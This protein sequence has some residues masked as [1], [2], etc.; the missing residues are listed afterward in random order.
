VK[1]PVFI[2]SLHYRDIVVISNNDCFLETEKH[3]LSDLAYVLFHEGVTK[4]FNETAVREQ[5]NI[6]LE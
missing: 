1:H 4:S 3:C 2:W 5:N 6:E